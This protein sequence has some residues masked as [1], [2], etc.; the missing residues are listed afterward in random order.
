MTVRNYEMTGN[1]CNL[2][3]VRG[4]KGVKKENKRAL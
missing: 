3:T 4:G 1:G 2:I